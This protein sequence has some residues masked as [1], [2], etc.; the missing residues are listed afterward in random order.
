LPSPNEFT[1]LADRVATLGRRISRKRELF[2]RL[3]GVANRI[4]ENDELNEEREQRET[5]NSLDAFRPKDARARRRARVRQETSSNG[6]KAMVISQTGDPTPDPFKSAAN[7]DKSNLAETVERPARDHSYPQ[8]STIEMSRSRQSRSVSLSEPSSTRSGHHNNVAWQD[9]LNLHCTFR[10]YTSREGASNSADLPSVAP[11]SISNVR[12]KKFGG[13]RP[14]SGMILKNLSS[15]SES[16]ST[17]EMSRAQPTCVQKARVSAELE[18]SSPESKSAAKSN[19][20]AKKMSARN[21]PTRSTMPNLPASTTRSLRED[22]VG[23]SI[24][25]EDLARLA[26]I[27]GHANHNQAL[28][29]FSDQMEDLIPDPQTFQSKQTIRDEQL[30]SNLYNEPWHLVAK[31]KCDEDAS[32]NALSYSARSFLSESGEIVMSVRNERLSSGILNAYDKFKQANVQFEDDYNEQGELETYRTVMST[33]RHDEVPKTSRSFSRLLEQA[34]IELAFPESSDVYDAKW[35]QLTNSCRKVKASS[36]APDPIERAKT[37]IADDTLSS[38]TPEPFGSEDHSRSSSYVTKMCLQMDMFSNERS[39][40]N[41]DKYDQEIATVSNVPTLVL[42]SQDVSYSTSTGSRE[43]PATQPLDPHALIQ[44]LSDVSLKRERQESASKKHDD[45]SRLDNAGVSS[46]LPDFSAK[47]ETWRVSARNTESEGKRSLTR[48]TSKIP[49]KISS[50]KNISFTNAVNN[51]A[52]CYKNLEASASKP[53]ND[54]ILAQFVNQSSGV[55]SEAGTKSI[56]RQRSATGSPYPEVCRQCFSQRTRD[57]SIDV[58]SVR[59]QSNGF[60]SANDYKVAL[61]SPHLQSPHA[62][63]GNEGIYDKTTYSTSNKSRFDRNIVPAISSNEGSYSSSRDYAK[64]DDDVRSKSDRSTSRKSAETINITSATESPYPSRYKQDSIPRN[65]EE[66][67]TWR[68][69]DECAS[70]NNEEDIKDL[71]DRDYDSY[72]NKAD[73]TYLRKEHSEPRIEELYSWGKKQDLPQIDLSLEIERISRRQANFA[74]QELNLYQNLELPQETSENLTCHKTQEISGFVTKVSSPTLGLT[75]QEPKKKRKSQE[76]FPFTISEASRTIVNERMGQRSDYR[77]PDNNYIEADDPLKEKA[78]RQLKP[79]PS[80]TRLASAG[81]ESTVAEILCCVAQEQRD[82]ES[83]ARSRMKA[84]VR[85]FSSKL[86]KSS[87]QRSNRRA[88]TE[89]AKIIYENRA[90]QVTSKTNSCSSADSSE[91]KPHRLNLGESTDNH[92]ID[93]SSKS[94]LFFDGNK[95]DSLQV[96]FQEHPRKYERDNLWVRDIKETLLAEQEGSKMTQQEKIEDERD[97]KDRYSIFLAKDFRSDKL[98]KSHDTRKGDDMPTCSNLISADEIARK[99]A[100]DDKFV[101]L[102]EIEDEDLT[103]CHC[104]RLCCLFAPSGDRFS[105]RQETPARKMRKSSSLLRKRK[106]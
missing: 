35:N 26:Y 71:E 36:E 77:S 91:E 99:T 66:N 25:Q 83:S 47:G 96:I 2:L 90:C 101:E 12:P 105:I 31:Y 63:Y 52:E 48:V 5:D 15:G 84:F 41:A 37:T 51:L 56:V 23:R 3:H 60:P 55:Q 67:A 42:N 11:F 87:K 70:I 21:D 20:L 73:E 1:L 95:S 9:K 94:V 40:S 17:S 88:N 13:Y 53:A 32:R 97:A 89:P 33:M 29:R 45:L 57:V 104:L 72:S 44:A 58:A 34:D 85:I 86:R 8:S 28:M 74:N 43:C 68:T 7:D 100:T 76:R 6:D 81:L 18:L 54:E 22:K 49:V 79:H 82:N 98:S 10:N 30:A 80:I 46:D 69:E 61:I 39:Q 102:Q 27:P 75:S 78:M 62:L 16:E 38:E 4:E 14:S 93:Q 19:G 106:K 59:T 92:W 50:S 103:G 64:I 65:V 24:S